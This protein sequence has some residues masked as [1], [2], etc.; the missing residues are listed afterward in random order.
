MFDIFGKNRVIKG[1]FVYLTTFI[2]F[3]W[4]IYVILTEIR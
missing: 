2:L 3:C 4:L 1:I